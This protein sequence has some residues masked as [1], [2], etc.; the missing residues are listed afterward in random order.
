[1]VIEW[2]G[3]YQSPFNKRVAPALKQIEKEFPGKVR[4]VWRSFPLDMFPNARSAQLAV[5]EANAQGKFKAMH[6]LLT[7]NP[8]KLNAGELVAYA[9]KA[10]V[11]SRKMTAAISSKRYDRQ[12]ERDID[13]GKAA[14]VRGVPAFRI[15][16]KLLS[17]A[18][19]VEKFRAAVREALH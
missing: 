2:F 13:A 9:Q 5:L 10:G 12:I 18:Q 16:G 11:D 1:V 4:F 8:T 6:E 3:D 7:E 17:G 15:N 19:P 14:G